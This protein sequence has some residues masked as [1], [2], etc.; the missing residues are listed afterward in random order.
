VFP[1]GFDP[2]ASGLTP[3][4]SPAGDFNA[5]DVLDV[6]DIDLW[7]LSTRGGYLGPGNRPFAMFDLNSDNA[8]GP[9]DLD[10]WVKDIKQTW[11][12]DADLNGEFNSADL[13]SVF[14]TGRYEDSFGGNSTWSAGDWNADGDFTTS[15]LVVAFQDGGYEAGLRVAV[16][17]VPE[18][19]ASLQFLLAVLGFVLSRRLVQ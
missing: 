1:E 18:P 6:A 9:E 15:D 10:V 12:G 14:Q 5:N 4:I 11:F 2:L 3:V 8:I 7:S 13:V 19:T 16:A 17:V